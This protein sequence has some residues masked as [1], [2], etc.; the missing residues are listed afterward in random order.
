MKQQ[1]KHLDIIQYKEDNEMDTK[2]LFMF[3]DMISESL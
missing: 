1:K 3:V 2:K